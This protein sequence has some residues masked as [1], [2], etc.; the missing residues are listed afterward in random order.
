MTRAGVPVLVACLLGIGVWLFLGDDAVDQASQRRPEGNLAETP[1]QESPDPVS[2]RTSR[3]RAPPRGRETVPEAPREFLP[4]AEAGV[5]IQVI[6]PDDEP[7]PHAIV[8]VWTEETAN[9]SRL[10]ALLREGRHA[11]LRAAMRVYRCGEDGTTR[12]PFFRQSGV[13]HAS[14]G[15]LEGMLRVDADDAASLD[16]KINGQANVV[17]EVVSETD[18][19]PV[20]SV[21][22]SFRPSGSVRGSPV[23]ETDGDGRARLRHLDW[24]IIDES[25]E[26]GHVAI[27]IPLAR[28]VEKK[29][30]LEELPE[31]PIVLRLPPT[32]RV[33]ITVLDEDA[34]PVDGAIVMLHTGDDGF[35]AGILGSAGALIGHTDAK[36]KVLFPFVGPELDLEVEAWTDA[37]P[38][39]SK[40]ALQTKT[41][42]GTTIEHTLTL[43]TKHTRMVGRFVDARGEPLPD[44]PV[45]VDIGSHD[46]LARS[47]H[48]GRFSFVVMPS[49]ADDPPGY[50]RFECTPLRLE[51]RV[52]L[53][54]HLPNGVF[55]VGDVTLE[56]LPFALAGR[57]VDADGTGVPGVR[58]RAFGRREPRGRARDRLAPVRTDADGVFVLRDEVHAEVIEWNVHAKHPQYAD[59]SATAVL[60]GTRDVLIR[61]ERPATCR[62]RVIAPDG[63]SELRATLRVGDHRIARELSFKG[64]DGTTTVDFG[65]LSSGEARLTLSVPRGPR[66]VEITGIQ[67][68]A[69]QE[70][71]DPRL[72]PIDLRTGFQVV[73]L[74]VVDATGQRIENRAIKGRVFRADG[75]RSSSRDLEDI[76]LIRDTDRLEV[77]ALGYR[78]VLLRRVTP[79][80]RVTLEPAAKIR[81]RVRGDAIPEGYELLALLQTAD[82]ETLGGSEVDPKTGLTGPID[83]R[84]PGRHVVRVYL[85]KNDDPIEVK[86]RID[87]EIPT[88]GD[89]ATVVVDVPAGT[90]AAAIR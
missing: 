37:V 56:A 87:V 25:P 29:V 19:S 63:I 41:A 17:V 89:T 1:T 81:L 86:R 21:P 90:L 85:L 20:A 2:A 11:F 16:V 27:E 31:D 22:V 8:R 54:E 28:K 32:G 57:V 33:A 44:L 59:A 66:L 68:V 52:R 3:F 39:P 55:D 48:E 53:P 40:G 77:S 49:A 83:T 51:G 71:D 4:A 14:K 6:G 30:R 7:V 13:L 82:E 23:V 43:R 64:E 58:V 45:M 10:F 73:Q 34:R 38:F 78:A 47:D 70:T 75:T 24:S 84:G 60:P 50:G 36:G 69:G 65:R 79:G 35:L 61:M 42:V 46:D 74:L 5:L 80:Q 67:L 9:R 76:G 15:D 26:R 72:D 62:A 18:G 88:G 12:V